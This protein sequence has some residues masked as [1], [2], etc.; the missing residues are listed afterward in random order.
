LV[1]K[2]GLIAAAAGDLLSALPCI[3]CA[4]VLLL[5]LMLQVGIPVDHHLLHMV[6]KGGLIVAAVGTVAATLGEILA[7]RALMRREHDKT[8][9]QVDAAAAAA[10]EAL[11]RAEH[12]GAVATAAAAAAAAADVQREVVDAA[13][14]EADS[15]AAAVVAEEEVLVGDA[16]VFGV[17]ENGSCGWQWDDAVQQK[18]ASSGKGDTS[19]DVGKQQQ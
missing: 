6:E 8:R 15:A 17:E 13:E 3:D 7:V 5:L 10:V 1:D 11:E 14:I 16:A 2:G 19:S 9:Q 4:L 18:N 12:N